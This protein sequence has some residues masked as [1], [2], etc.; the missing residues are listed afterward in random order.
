MFPTAYLGLS[1]CAGLIRYLNIEDSKGAVEA[2]NG[3]ILNNYDRPLEVKYAENVQAKEQRQG[4]IDKP[5]HA[6]YVYV[7]W[8]YCATHAG[9]GEFPCTIP[10]VQS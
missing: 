4:K 2:L 10:Y 6:E 8:W 3:V 7:V 9:S 1:K 5:H